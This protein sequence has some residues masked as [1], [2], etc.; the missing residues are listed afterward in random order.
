MLHRLGA[1]AVGMS[2]V[3]EVHLA[4]ALGMRVLGISCITNKATGFGAQRLDHAEVTEVAAR[5][6]TRF[7]QLLTGILDSLP[8]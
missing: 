3:L 1:D 5:V 4:A 8:G 2:T 7:T 6:R